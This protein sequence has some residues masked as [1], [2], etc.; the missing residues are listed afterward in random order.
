MFDPSLLGTSHGKTIY[1]SQK[2]QTEMLWHM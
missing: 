2:K 1:W